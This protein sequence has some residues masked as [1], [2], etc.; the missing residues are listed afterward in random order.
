MQHLRS[1]PITL[2]TN[3]SCRGKDF[4]LKSASSLHL[5]QRKENE[6]LGMELWT[7]LSTVLGRDVSAKNMEKKMERYETLLSR[8]RGR[9][10]GVEDSTGGGRDGEGHG[11][12]LIVADTSTG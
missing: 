7:G 9:D 10:G 2:N 11:I 1:T 5:L 3:E 4:S 6:A 12:Q 8:R